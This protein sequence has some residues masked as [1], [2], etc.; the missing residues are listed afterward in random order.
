MGNQSLQKSKQHSPKDI[1]LMVS[2]SFKMIQIVR[3][4]W[5]ESLKSK[6]M[7]IVSLMEKNNLDKEQYLEHGNENVEILRKIQAANQCLKIMRSMIDQLPA[8]IKC[9]NDLAAFLKVKP[10][11]NTL[12][13]TIQKLEINQL[14]ISLIPKI[15]QVATNFYL[16]SINQLDSVDPKH[17]L[18]FKND[19]NTLQDEIGKYWINFIKRKA[20]IQQTILFEN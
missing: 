6:E 1:Q 2:N 8:L 9:Q 19:S 20:D 18:L 7:L 14:V 17:V 4:H 5:V 13:W 12:I 15:E 16:H 3:N 11:L 10:G